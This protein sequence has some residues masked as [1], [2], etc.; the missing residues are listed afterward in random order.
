[1]P[2]GRETAKEPDPRL[3]RKGIRRYGQQAEARGV[4]RDF[5]SRGKDDDALHAVRED[6]PAR[7]ISMVLCE[8][9]ICG[10]SRD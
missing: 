3:V 10:G 6:A 2:G 7:P 4:F 9:R 8:L 5:H 1:M